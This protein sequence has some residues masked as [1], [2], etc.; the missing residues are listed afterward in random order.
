MSIRFENVAEGQDAEGRVANLVRVLDEENTSV[1]EAVGAFRWAAHNW[2][3]ARGRIA[4]AAKLTPDPDVQRVLAEALE[5]EDEF[6][7]V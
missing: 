5:V 4:E 6:V 2:L 7:D 1:A 3:R